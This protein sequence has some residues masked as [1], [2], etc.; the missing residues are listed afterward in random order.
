M[1]D[2]TVLLDTGKEVRDIGMIQDEIRLTITSIAF[3]HDELE[4]T[5]E[6]KTK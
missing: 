2:E 6:R 4:E 5:D 1:A 3:R